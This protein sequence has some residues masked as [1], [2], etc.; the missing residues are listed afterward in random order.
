MVLD[1][2][3]SYE[4]LPA[5]YKRIQEHITANGLELIENMCEEELNNYLTYKDLNNFII[6][7]SVGVS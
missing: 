6:R 7:I 4:S 2:A 5:T 3:G 1:H